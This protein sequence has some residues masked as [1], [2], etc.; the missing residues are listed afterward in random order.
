MII[1]VFP[2]FD[3]SKASEVTVKACGMLN[4]MG[5]SVYADEKCS[6]YFEDLSFVELMPRREASRLC[7]I[8]IA[9][10]G[11]GT[12]LR[13]SDYASEFEKPMLGINTG[14]L[15]FMA[16]MEI[17]ELDSL[18]KL[19]SGDFNVEDRMMIKAEAA[20]NPIRIPISVVRFVR[21]L[22]GAPSV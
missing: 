11:D 10:G 13:N 16:S 8:I 14:R 21:G 9:I 5:V 6:E 3:K 4:D 18:S 2:N 15:G 12:I 17:D 19:I 1:A 22:T 7:D 20:R